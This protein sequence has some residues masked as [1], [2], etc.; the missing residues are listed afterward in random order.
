MTPEEYFAGE[1]I[2]QIRR[3][4]IR[5]EVYAMSGSTPDHNMI[6]L[7]LATILRKQVRGTECHAFVQDIKVR[8][9][10]VDVFYY[11]D[12]TVTCDPR[13]CPL[14]DSFIRYPCLIVEVLSPST[15]AFDRGDKFADYRQIETLKE[16]VLVN[17]TRPSVECFRLN[18][19]GR[20]ELYSYQ[21][22]KQILLT[23]L[24]LF[25]DMATLY[26]D[27]W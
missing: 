19:M 11:P 20:W 10:A 25:I 15:E 26:E 12:L 24:N 8:I 14:T 3:E 9:E 6:T 7:N 4:Y 5:G 17:Q 18:E 1:E 13:D 22:P 16:Y 2:S 21:D 23:S 27:V